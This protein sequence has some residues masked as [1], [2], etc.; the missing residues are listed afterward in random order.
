MVRR[1]SLLVAAPLAATL[2]GCAPTRP[3]AAPAAG[4]TADLEAGK[5]PAA[6]PYPLRPRP[7]VAP[8]G[9]VVSDA[10]LATHV[11]VEVL[12][13]GGNAVDAAVATAFALAVVY[14]EAGNLGGG[15]FMV[16]R[17]GDGRTAALDF[18][19]MAPAA[20]TR[21]MYLDEK[22]QLTD[23]SI[24][25]HLASGVPGS[26]MGLWEAHKRFGTRPWPELLA[27]A[28]RLAEQGFRVDEQ[29]HR[30]IANAA[31]RLAKYPASAALF[32]PGGQPPAV[33]STFRNPDLAAVLK[34]IAEQGPAGFYEGE[35]AEL[36][37]AEMK[38][39]GG[40]ITTE[41]LKRYRAH[42][43]E[44]VEFVY[45]GHR[46]L[47][48]PPASSGGLTL[49]LMANILDGYDL[50]ALGWHSPAALH[51]MAEASR[52]A[53]A[54]RNEFLADPDFVDVPA[55]RF[56]SPEYA[57][58]LRATISRDRATPSAQIRPGL[59]ALRDGNHTTHFGVVDAQGGAVALTTTLNELYGS[60]VTIAG[61]GIVMNDEMDD[62]AAKPGAPNMF[63]LVQGEANAIAPG[64]RPLSAMTPTI[65]LDEDG[66]PLLV[67]GARGGPRIIS[68][69]FDVLSNVLDYGMDV[70]AA[71]NA[72]RIHHQHL[73]DI[74]YYEEHGLTPATIQALEAMGH[75]VEP[76]D[77]VANAPS[78]LRRGGVWT[79]WA[80]PRSGGA[81]DGY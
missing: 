58:K 25:G 9:M 16:V 38:R 74:L 61:T 55:A 75:K 11:G 28:I 50:K 40:I 23:K 72:P 81:A 18:R 52:R 22:G 33:G 21:D 30:S 67:T 1:W 51:L 5:V 71:V 48:M 49:A 62:F 6:W 63:G 41:D 20:A 10:P 78:I 35:T 80:D 34:R 17:M 27:P 15:G 69:T 43:R 59:A 3:A 66:R 57:A 45:R 12:R 68:A 37:A 42:W 47:S 46:V 73:P 29:L 53:F 70:A 56:L 8:H 31:K 4:A 54:D 19:E 36:I 2:A 14:P 39:G 64:K 13:A 76:R 44:P 26:V 79:A 24:N 65:V 32:L 60:G 77:G 7:V